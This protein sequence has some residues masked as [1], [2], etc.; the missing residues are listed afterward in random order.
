MGCH[1]VTQEERIV[2]PDKFDVVCAKC[3]AAQI[4]KKDL[5][6]VRLPEL[7]VNRID[8]KKVREACHIPKDPSEGGAEDEEFVSISTETVSLV[9]AYLLNVPEDDPEVYSKNLQELIL[10]MVEKS[11]APLAELIDR[12]S[13]VPVAEKMLAGLNPE[14]IK[15][16]AC[17]WGLNVEYEPPA[18]ASFGGWHADLL[19]IRYTPVGH[20]DPV[21]KSWVDFALTIAPHEKDSE[22]S[23]RALALRDQMLS[24]KEGVGGCIKCHAVTAEKTKEGKEFLTVHWGYLGPR[25]RPYSKYSHKNHLDIL[26]KGDTC[27]NC[28]LLNKDADYLSS[29]D[30]FAPGHFVSN[31][32]SIERSTCLE[33]HTEGKVKQNC[34]LC[35]VYHF[36]PGF[37]KDM[38]LAKHPS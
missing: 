3:H 31:F 4:P 24:P 5:V 7:D 37:K 35:H 21:A 29:F 22:K 6:L 27:M 13:P 28:H 10:A 18:Q 38:L 1:K 33:C 32:S 2:P 14:V 34:Q 19:E 25:N 23:E 30:A 11:T 36:K 20:K 26:G 8:P 17:A 16:T 12:H 9:S 15:R